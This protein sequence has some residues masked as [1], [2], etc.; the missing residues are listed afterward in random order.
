MKKL[1]IENKTDLSLNNIFTFVHSIISSGRI[2]N[3]GT[4]YCYLTAFELH[5]RVFRVVTDLN[6]KS[7]KF[8]IYEVG[9]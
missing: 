3:N 4:Q 5:N 7:D 6:K 1:I 9:C 2:S 8:T